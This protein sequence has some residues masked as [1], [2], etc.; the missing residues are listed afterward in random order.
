MQFKSPFRRLALFGA[1]Y[2][3]EGAVLTYFSTFNILYL[4]TFNLSF[5]RIG[6][7]GGITLIPFVL[8][9][10]IGLL[11]DRVNLVGLGHRKPYI[12][13]GLVLQSAAFL[14]FPL[15]DPAGQFPLFVVTC[16]LAALGM[17]TYDTC[18]DGFSIDVTPEEERGVVQGIM[19]G[20]RA[21]SAVVIAAVIGALSQ[22]GL[23]PVVF[24]GIG[25]LGQPLS[26]AL[27]DAFGFRWMFA[28]LAA[29]NLLTLPLVYGV[30]RLRKD[31]G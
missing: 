16:L 3:V 22:A 9:V 12:V 21:L 18:T 19:V 28:V 23:W 2:F 15:I 17:S 25:G 31:A 6:V 10:F 20:G 8:K 24:A 7:V 29:L 13:L 1:V 27:V 26:G 11:S 30:F 5:T 4:R 14:V